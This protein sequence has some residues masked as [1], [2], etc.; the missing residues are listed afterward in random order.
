MCPTFHRTT[1][2]NNYLFFFADKLQELTEASNQASAASQENPLTT[3][4]Y[5]EVLR[6]L[7]T[8][9]A[10]TD[11]NRMLRDERDQLQQRIREIT[12]RNTKV[13]QEM[14]PLKEKNRELNTRT[15]E[16]TSESAKLR[17]EANQ[18]RQRANAL[19]ERSNK[20][21]EDFKRLQNERENLAKMLTAEKEK[22]E[23][24]ETELASIRQEKSRVDAELAALTKTNQTLIEEKRKLAEEIL[25]LKQSNGRI[26]HEIIEVKSKLLQRDDDIK[27]M[28]EELT[29]KEL[30]LTDSRNKEIQIRKIA[31]KY[32]D[33]FFDL[34]NKEDERKAEQAARPI[35]QQAA[36]V[37]E[38]G[39]SRAQAEKSLNDRIKELDNSVTE[40]LEENDLLRAET[41]S[42]NKKLKE[43]EDAHSNILKELNHTIVTLTEEKKTITRELALTKTSLLNCEASRTEHDTLKVQNESRIT[44]LEKELADLDKENK[45]AV[46]RLSRENET[47]QQRLANL[48]SQLQQGIKPT[49]STSVIEKSPSDPARTANVKPMAGPSTQQ[50]AAVTPRRGGDTPL[51]SI[52]PMSVQNSRTA[53]VLP[54]SQTSSNIAAVHGTS[55]T[56]ITPSTSER[57]GEKRRETDRNSPPHQTAT[58]QV[59]TT[60]MTGGEVMSTTSSHTDYMPA[61][62]SAAAIVIVA[63]PPMGSGS[64][65]NIQEAESVEDSS[66]S[67]SS[68]QIVIQQQTVALVSPRQHENTPQNIVAPQQVIIDHLHATASTSASSSTST[69]DQSSITMSTHNRAT[70]TSNTVTTSQAGHK[71]PRET[72]TDSSEDVSSDRSNIK[73][74]QTKRTRIQIGSSSQGVSESSCGEVEYQVPTSSQRDQDDDNIIVVDSGEDDE[75][76]D[77]E[78][79]VE[80]DDAPFEDDGDNVEQFDIEDGYGQAQGVA[81]EGETADIYVEN[82]Q[83]D[84]NEVDVED[85]SEIPNQSENQ[86]AGVA[87]DVGT[88][89]A[90]GQSSTSAASSNTANLD[91]ANNTDT[92]DPQQPQENQQIQT[93][94][95][96]SDAGSS[97]QISTAETSPWRQTAATPMRQHQNST[98]QGQTPQQNLGGLGYEESGDDSIVPSTPTLYVPRRADGFSEAVSS[99]HLQVAA[100]FTYESGTRTN[101]T[102]D[103]IDDTSVDLMQLDES[104]ASG[105]PTVP[106]SANLTE[107]DAAG[108]SGTAT[109]APSVADI[110]PIPGTSAGE[111]SVPDIVIDAEGKI[112]ECQ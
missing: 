33:S 98:Q 78:G 105:V 96:G 91:D 16:L 46:A 68:T 74:P 64:A 12:A 28:V 57:N 109:T 77:D 70:S 13:E 84:T 75:M 63:V 106:P 97:T 35:E 87:S 4:K 42:L 99:P 26:S 22:I 30:Q 71:R 112:V 15:D 102:S 5:Q 108:P 45:E 89:Q 40:K 93:I 18:W 100:R 49:T 76:P 1:T 37:N 81:Y 110:E 47:L 36:D 69:S 29:A 7:E 3:A 55:I 85:S 58:Q 24:F 111:A 27:K 38:A 79:P 62:S 92:T 2:N 8:L 88:S 14:F 17:H 107:P 6:K 51:A 10:V 101:L 21:P 94:S 44:R 41:E 11:S 20:N 50:S 90:I 104:V 103:G 34:Q 54:T 48:R 32:K 66:S 39:Q 82:M 56:A 52:R 80:P 95:S 61:T 65:E 23:R 9:N 31:K 72:E 86:A 67:S 43:R 59:H 19:V 53:A 73:K 25:T 83:S 60:G